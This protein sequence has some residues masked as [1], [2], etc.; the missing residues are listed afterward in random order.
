LLYSSGGPT[1]RFRGIV[2][3]VS[4]AWITRGYSIMLVA[5]EFTGF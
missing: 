4:H 2:I 3:T 5:N 1:P